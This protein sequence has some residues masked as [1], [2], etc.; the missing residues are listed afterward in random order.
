M[1]LYT[2][3]KRGQ[4]SVTHSFLTSPKNDCTEQLY[5]FVLALQL[6]FLWILRFSPAHPAAKERQTCEPVKPKRKKG[7]EDGRSW[8]SQETT[9]AVLLFQLDMLRTWNNYQ[10]FCS[11]KKGEWRKNNAGVCVCVWKVKNWFLQTEGGLQFTTADVKEGTKKPHKPKP[12][13]SEASRASKACKE[14]IF[15]KTYLLWKLKNNFYF[16]WKVL[17]FLN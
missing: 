3:I 1:R 7:Y 16:Q 13:K 17:H 10:D 5:C 6:S 12:A 8:V 4:L 2:K 15:L 9:R 14:Y 11:A